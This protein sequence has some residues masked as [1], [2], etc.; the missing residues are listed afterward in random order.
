MIEFLFSTGLRISQMLGLTVKQFSPDN[1]HF[2]TRSV[3]KGGGDHLI[4]VKKELFN[5]VREFFAGKVYLF[6]QETGEPFR[7]ERITMRIKRAS[8]R[9]LGQSVGSHVM[10]HSIATEIFKQ[11]KDILKTADLLGHKDPSVTARLYIH[12]GISRK[13]K[14]D[15]V[16]EA[17]GQ[18]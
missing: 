9:I 16:S 14:D 3:G 18:D 15:I 10:R 4:E 8:E 11:T 6:E 5:R 17:L 1:A 12:T 13:E 2:V 7:R